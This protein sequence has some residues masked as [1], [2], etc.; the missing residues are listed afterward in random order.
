MGL[1]FR[2]RASHRPAPVAD[3]QAAHVPPVVDVQLDDG[4]VFGG[5]QQVRD[6]EPLRLAADQCLSVATVEVAHLDA[7][8]GGAGE[9]ADPASPRTRHHV[10]PGWHIAPGE[11]VKRRVFKTSALPST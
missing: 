3:G 6:L 11:L 1:P 2:A 8:G 5:E 4:I 7:E 10:A 9:A